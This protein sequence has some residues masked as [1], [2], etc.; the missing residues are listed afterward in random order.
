MFGACFQ[1][2]HSAKISVIVSGMRFAVTKVQ[3][4]PEVL[5]AFLFL[6]LEGNSL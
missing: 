3:A 4:L 2:M 1:E 5:E 6:P